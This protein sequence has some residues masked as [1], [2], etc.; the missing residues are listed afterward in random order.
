MLVGILATGTVAVYLLAA[1]CA[2]P[3][4]NL[5]PDF[6]GLRTPQLNLATANL[7]GQRAAGV[8][9]SPRASSILAL[10]KTRPARYQRRAGPTFVRRK[11]GRNR[12][13]RGAIVN[14]FTS[15]DYEPFDTMGAFRTGR[16]KYSAAVIKVHL[17]LCH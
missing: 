5:T 8:H 13:K 2:A 3:N 7:R 16:G 15:W 10:T 1:V 12:V 6:L 17:G 14:G 11:T 9:R 4:R